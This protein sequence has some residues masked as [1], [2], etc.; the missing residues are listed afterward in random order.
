MNYQFRWILPKNRKD[1]EINSTSL[2][3]KLSR[4]S[5]DPEAN[6]MM[7]IYRAV[8][9]LSLDSR[10]YEVFVCLF[11]FLFILETLIHLMRCNVRM[12]IELC[13]GNL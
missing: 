1:D 8:V 4:V 7:H 3:K 13:D 12:I 9:F 2:I 10:V 6:T 5:D 11:C